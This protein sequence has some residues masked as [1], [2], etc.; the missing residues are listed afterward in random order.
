LLF[1]IFFSLIVFYSLFQLVLEL[2]NWAWVRR[3]KGTVPPEFAG[4]V[5]SEKVARI[6]AYTRSRIILGLLGDI[7]GKVLILSLLLLDGFAWLSAEVEGLGLGYLFTGLIFFG[8][9]ALA[10]GLL[11]LP[12][13]WY[14]TFRIEERFGFNRMGYKLWILDLIKG[15]IVGAIIGGILL[16][17]IIILLYEAGP[18]WWLICWAAVF[19]FSLILTVLYPLWIAPLFNKFTPI[20]E[21]D[22]RD[23]VLKLMEQAGIRSREVLVMDAG[24]R[25]AHTNAYFTGLGRTKR[26]VFYD[27]LMEKHSEEECLAVLAHEAG[28]WRKKH[29]LKH[30]ALSQGVSFGLFAL[31]GWLIAWAPLYEAFGFD[32]IKSYAGLF[33]ISLVYSPVMFF[34]QPALA[35][36]SRRFEFEADRFAGRELGSGQALSDMLIKSSLDNLS[37]LNP[38]PLYV[39]FHYSHPTVVERVRDLKAGAASRPA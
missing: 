31:T 36:L 33:L 10:S 17:V 38:H 5:E 19:G 24:K 25:S 8:I 14:A 21:G 18:L 26:I 16:G 27:T 23:R 6:E 3:H 34:V 37:N 30:L 1:W 32:G 11:S 15:L 39:F 9:M 22:F 13:E 2:V 4:L 35:W 29:V 28:H 12:F 7:F 20:E